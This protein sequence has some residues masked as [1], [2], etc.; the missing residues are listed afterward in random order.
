MI[1]PERRVLLKHYLEEGVPVAVLARRLKIGRRTIQR[2]IAAGQTDRDVDIADV[3]YTARPE[4]P[5]KLDAYKELIEERLREYPELTAVRLYGE[6]AAAGYTG[7]MSQLRAFVRC[8]RPQAIVDPVVRF[9][10]PPGHQAQVDFAEFQFPWGKRHALLVVL[11]YSRLLWF[12]F[13]ERQDMQT[14]FGGIEESFTFFGGVPKELLFDQMKSVVTRDERRHGGRLVENMEFLRFA[15]HW[16]FKARACRPYRAQTKGKVERP[17]RYVRQ[18]FVYG[19][20]FVSD[21]DLDHQRRTWLD[22][23]AN[24]R[25]HQT[26]KEVPVIRFER[27]ERAL[28]QPLAARAY[29]PLVSVPAPAPAS[30]PALMPATRTRERVLPPV[31]KIEVEQRSLAAYSRLTADFASESDACLAGAASGAAR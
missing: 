14:L 4:R 24:A 11:G 9:E 17:I 31:P 1:D 16:G 26:T 27:N 5:A 6:I 29:H 20:E 30:A 10:T 18:S 15:A 3:R 22:D 7:G 2:W 28:L 13:Y 25:L 12:R 21:G 19:R 8:T 23:V